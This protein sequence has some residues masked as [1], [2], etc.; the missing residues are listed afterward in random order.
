MNR[1]IADADYIYMYGVIPAEELQRSTFPS[2]IGIDQNPVTVKIF[3]DLAAIITS[4]HSQQYSQQQIDFQLKDAQWIK[5]K[6]FHHHECISIFHQQ[7]TVLPMA[8]CTIFQN[9]NNLE[10]L[11]N[12]EYDTLFKKLSFIGDKQEWNLKLFCH[13]EQA[14]AFVLRHNSAVKELQEK[15]A[16]M[17]AGKQFL[18]KKKLENLI[19][20]EFE[21]EQNRW[22]QE[23]SQQLK[24]FVDNTNLR[25]NWGR[26]VTERKEEMLVNCDFLI[27]KNKSDEFLTKIEEIEVSYEAL[28]CTFY[29]TGPWPPYHFSKMGEER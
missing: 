17:P 9:N 27:D 6:A 21:T 10:S 16:T 13:M 14:L 19:F 5:E 20:S 4:V 22:W 1:T 11:L 3:K 15:L 8:F 26:D 25:R 18:M 23:I 28:G 7:F 12:N 2:F 29:L 24:P